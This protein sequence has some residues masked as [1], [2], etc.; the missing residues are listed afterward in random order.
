MMGAATVEKIAINAVMVAICINH[1]E[2]CIKKDELNT[3]CLLRQGQS[4]RIC[5]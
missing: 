5:Q 1:D 3:N 2:F 4:P